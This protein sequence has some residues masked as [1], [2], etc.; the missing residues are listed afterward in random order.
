MKQVSNF[1]KV[2]VSVL[3]V[4]CVAS[5]FACSKDDENKKEY[6]SELVGNWESI[7]DGPMNGS[8]MSLKSNGTAKDWVR[9]GSEWVEYYSYTWYV[10]NGNLVLVYENGE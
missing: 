1:A 9:N 3:M 2:L 6:P 7:G 4:L 10:Q 8:I 5:F